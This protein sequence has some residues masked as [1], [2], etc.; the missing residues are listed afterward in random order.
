[1][2]R[3]RFA[4][5]PQIQQQV[6]V[7]AAVDEFSSHGFHD[8]SLNRVIEAARISKGSMYYY[9][10][11]KEDLFS[12]VTRTEL[13]RLVTARG[14][15]L[16]PAADDGETFWSILTDYYLR[17]MDALLASPKL[18]ALLR[19]WSAASQ[20]SALQQAQQEA[21]RALLPWLERTLTIGQRVGA[22]RTDLPPGLLIAVAAA[23]GQ[24][25]DSWLVAVQPSRDEL[26][27]LIDDL[28]SMIRGALEP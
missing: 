16:P 9:F 6:I 21:E 28:V 11:S 23:M 13:E 14:P 24:A 1:M 12:Y 27:G 10:D 19:A 8:A 25:M 22:I 15:F 17:L 4:R 3:P 5:L 7:Q 18:A 26:P 2:V 20:T